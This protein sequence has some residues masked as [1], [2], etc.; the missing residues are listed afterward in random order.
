MIVAKGNVMFAAFINPLLF[1]LRGTRNSL[2]YVS[3]QIK[4]IVNPT[5]QTSLSTTAPEESS[6]GISAR[7]NVVRKWG[8]S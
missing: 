8:H 5:S 6:P 1:A 2:T 3:L 4:K 7:E